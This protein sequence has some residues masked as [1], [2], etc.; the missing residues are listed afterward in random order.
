MRLKALK[1][2]KLWNASEM[3]P[4]KVTAYSIAARSLAASSPACVI[5]Y[6]IT[7]IAKLI[8]SL[9]CKMLVHKTFTYQVFVSCLEEGS[10][11]GGS[12]DG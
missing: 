10:L 7:C 8:E 4:A 9:S 6:V 3:A 5:N 1:L 2:G 11:E 12:F